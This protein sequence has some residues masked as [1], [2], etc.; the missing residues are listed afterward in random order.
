LGAA[1]NRSKKD[2]ATALENREIALPMVLLSA[3]L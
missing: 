3:T 1:L 2:I